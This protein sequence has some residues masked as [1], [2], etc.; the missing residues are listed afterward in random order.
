MIH[1][2]QHG[3]ATVVLAA[4]INAFHVVGKPFETSRIVVSGAGA[5]GTA[6]TRLLL[7]AGAHD[8]TVWAPVGVFIRASTNSSPSTSGGW[9]TT[10]THDAS[11][12][13]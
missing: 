4:L 6:V 13:D 12:A 9:P 10:P 1:D 3:T 11:K 8:V 7:A 5:A 2:D